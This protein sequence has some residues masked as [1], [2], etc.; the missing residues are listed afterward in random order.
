MRMKLIPT[1]AMLLILAAAL[2]GCQRRE[3][4]QSQR[5]IR[6][7]TTTSTEN[8]GLLDV[9]LPAFRER[10]GIEVQVMPMGTGKALRIAR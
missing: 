4:S 7:A 9:L 5:T 10:T 8:S 1:F 3:A 2:A 6:L